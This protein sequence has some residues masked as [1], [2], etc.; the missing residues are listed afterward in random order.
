M[1]D[2]N[3]RSGNLLPRQNNLEKPSNSSFDSDKNPRKKTTILEKILR[4][5]FSKKQAK[6]YADRIIKRAEEIGIS[7]K[8]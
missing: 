8:N 5:R 6:L 7:I 1:P 4:K 2:F 3:I